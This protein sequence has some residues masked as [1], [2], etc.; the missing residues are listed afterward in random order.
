M[1][2]CQAGIN[3]AEGCMKGNPGMFALGLVLV[4]LADVSH[5]QDD[6]A[7]EAEEANGTVEE[8]MGLRRMLGTPEIRAVAFSDRAEDLSGNCEPAMAR[9]GQCVELVDFLGVDSVLDSGLPD[10][11]S[12]RDALRNVGDLYA[13][14]MEDVSYRW[15]SSE[16][17]QDAFNPFGVYRIPPAGDHWEALGSGPGDPKFGLPNSDYWVRGAQFLPEVGEELPEGLESIY[18]YVRFNHEPGVAEPTPYAVLSG[19]FADRMIFDEEPK[20][21]DMMDADPTSSAPFFD[22][23]YPYQT[24]RFFGA[25][26]LG[27]GDDV[28]SVSIPLS[29]FEVPP[30]LRSAPRRSHLLP[31]NL[32]DETQLTLGQTEALEERIS[33]SSARRGGFEELLFIASD[34]AEA[35]QSIA[36]VEYEGFYRDIGAQVVKFGREN[37]TPTHLRVLS[38]LFAM[39][40]PPGVNESFVAT[41]L[42]D[43]DADLLYEL[44][45]APE[46]LPE[47]E[48]VDESLPQASENED[49]YYYEDDEPLISYVDDDNVYNEAVNS[50]TEDSHLAFSALPPRLVAAHLGDL[51]SARGLQEMDQDFADWMH[52]EFSSSADQRGLLKDRARAVQPEPE[53]TVVQW[54]GRYSV[55]YA[56]GANERAVEEGMNRQALEYVVRQAS[57][58]NLAE[59]D[60]MET[61][62]L[63]DH[64][65]YAIA[66]RFV[67]DAPAEVWATSVAQEALAEEEWVEV[68]AAHDYFPAP[69]DEPT[70]DARNS[71][72]DPLSVCTTE[73]DFRLAAEEPLFGAVNVDLLIVAKDGRDLDNPLAALWDARDRVPF[74]WIDDPRESARL[75]VM[76]RLVGLPDDQAIYRVRWRVWTGW[77]LFWGVEGVG[78]VQWKGEVPEAA[79]SEHLL[80]MRRHYDW[81][82]E[83]SGTPVVAEDAQ[84]VALRTGA[85]CSDLALV[86]PDLVPTLVRAS[87]LDENFRPT[88]PYDSGDRSAQMRGGDLE[89][90][91]RLVGNRN[92]DARTTGGDGAEVGSA[93]VDENEL[94]AV[95]GL[96]PPANDP[97]NI[98]DIRG[99]VLPE[100]GQLSDDSMNTPT[101]MVVFDNRVTERGARTR[102]FQPRVPYFRE[103]RGTRGS[104]HVITAGW[105]LAI[106]PGEVAEPM[107]LSPDW[108]DTNSVNAENLQPRWRQRRTLHFTMAGDMALR[109][110]SLTAMD[111]GTALEFDPS[112]GPCVAPGQDPSTG[113][114]FTKASGVL[115]RYTLLQTLWL[116]SNRRLAVEY[117]LGIGMAVQFKAFGFFW[118]DDLKRESE[119]INGFFGSIFGGPVVGIRGGSNPRP[120]FRSRGRGSLWGAKARDESSRRGRTEYGLRVG[121][122]FSGL[123]NTG[124]AAEFHGDGWWAR[125]ITPSRAKNRMFTAYHP[126]F[127]VGPFVGGRYARDVGVDSEGTARALGYRA[128]VDVGIRIQARLFNYG[129]DAP[130]AGLK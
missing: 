91:A 17:V 84:R 32:T 97:Q 99:W 130:T 23:V 63:L 81:L 114:E 20:E 36:S 120:L 64:V 82:R 122:E 71:W 109:P 5:A 67:E 85:I 113:R 38:T 87:L 112:S 47:D 9:V 92:V 35:A 127:L 1:V 46:S 121:V 42:V 13:R 68:L 104:D 25:G 39:Q 126:S 30:E 61:S 93:I 106:P 31:A 6:A 75:P 21:F 29:H 70:D 118:T 102:Q 60:L 83:Y 34:S 48:T 89:L 78:S 44:R 57:A 56:K 95:V 101:L 24:A 90:G 108:V 69:L 40:S 105:A 52:E 124:L 28:R 98:S 27:F 53:E 51:S 2:E 94:E 76:T 79:A 88:A 123:T 111:C 80:W 72:Y 73:R 96:L 16:T 33:R 129:G 66:D 59:A 100:I 128:S 103:D 86:D 115:A 45:D 54:I 49:I 50:I 116:G 26:D 37:Y 3:L 4:A 11:R 65:R 18:R 58:R 14:I 7:E 62:L 119:R 107:M 43:S 41:A 77:H 15:G 12:D 117:G 19:R 55:R 10:S 8:P 22:Q 125:S 110:Y 74:L